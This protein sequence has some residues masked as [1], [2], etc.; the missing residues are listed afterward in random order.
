MEFDSDNSRKNQLDKKRHGEL[1]QA[2]LSKCS[3]TFVVTLNVTYSS[4]QDSTVF[5]GVCYRD[6]TSSDWDILNGR[7]VYILRI[8]PLTLPYSSEWMD[9]C[10]NETQ[11][12]LNTLF[13]LD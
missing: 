12:Q 10:R 11:R 1:I 5:Q 7:S 2:L 8:L 6:M 4:G 3:Q 13:S 9:A